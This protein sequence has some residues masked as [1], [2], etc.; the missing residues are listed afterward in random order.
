MLPPAFVSIGV[1]SSPARTRLPPP[2]PLKI[3]AIFVE[4]PLTPVIVPPTVNF[5]DVSVVVPIE[6]LPVLPP[7]GFKKRLLVVPVGAIMRLPL[8]FEIGPAKVEVEVLV[9]IK[10]VSVVV[11]AE[12][13]EEKV[14]AP[15]TASVPKVAVWEKRLVDDAVVEKKLVVVPLVRKR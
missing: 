5:A 7:Y 3:V 13:V 4:V 15:A 8:V 11:P 2:L 10:L 9:T 6:T 12:S 14:V 1:A